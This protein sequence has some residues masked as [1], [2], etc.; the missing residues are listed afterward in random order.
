MLRT[1][2]VARSLPVLPSLFFLIS[3]IRKMCIKETYVKEY[4]KKITVRFMLVTSSPC[5]VRA[6]GKSEVISKSMFRMWVRGIYFNLK[7]IKEDPGRRA[8]GKK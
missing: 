3:K 8:S 6:Q 1:G 5:P 4:L 7:E 2:L